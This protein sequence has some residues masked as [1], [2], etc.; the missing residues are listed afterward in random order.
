M[1]LKRG[2]AYFRSKMSQKVQLLGSMRHHNN[3][4][5]CWTSNP[6]AVTNNLTLVRSKNDL[7]QW[8]RFFLT[9]VIQTAENSV[10]TL[11]KIV[12]LK[13]SIE[14]EKLLRLGK[15][16]EKGHEFFAQLFK[17]PRVTVKDVQDMTGLS[18]KVANDLVQAFV[19]QNILV[20]TTGYQGR[21]MCRRQ[22]AH[23]SR[24]MPLHFVQ[25]ILRA[26]LSPSCGAITR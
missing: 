23:Q 19:D 4:T 12:E 22:E 24:T 17:K 7:G 5:N 18:S 10:L 21:R 1:S 11:E 14:K 9:G 15:R 3:T 25:H 6:G 2:G 13:A 16:T 26:T 8:L 20:E